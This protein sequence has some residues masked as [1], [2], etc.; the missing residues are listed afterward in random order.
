MQGQ[1]KVQRSSV[2]DPDRQ[3][4]NAGT[5]APDALVRGVECHGDDRRIGKQLRAMI[6]GE[7]ERLMRDRDH[8]V[9]SPAPILPADVVGEGCRRLF[10][11]EAVRLQI[12]GEIVDRQIRA[13]A[14][15][16]SNAGIQHG[17]GEEVFGPRVNRQHRLVQ[18]R[19]RGGGRACQREG[20]RSQRHH[21]SQACVMSAGHLK[22]RVGRPAE[23]DAT[24]PPRP[25]EGASSRSCR[26]SACRRCCPAGRSWG[27]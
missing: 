25:S 11:S 7:L 5:S 22:T 13:R 10:R 18:F 3:G 9:D 17:I 2:C 14:Q 16:L 27:G 4:G 24:S 15:R 1:R 6:E 26:T 20:D 12:L 19:L 23:S 8:D 21:G